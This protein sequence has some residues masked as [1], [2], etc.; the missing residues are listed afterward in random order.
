MKFYT[1]DD[2]RAYVAKDD[3]IYRLYSDGK[4]LKTGF[5]YPDPMKWHECDKEEALETARIYEG[6]FK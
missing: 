5:L 2:D 4:E 3:G 1:D 6:Y